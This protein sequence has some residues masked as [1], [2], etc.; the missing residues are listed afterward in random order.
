LCF[1]FSVV[2]LGFGSLQLPA[3][4]GF[5][6]LSPASATSRLTELSLSNLAYPFLP[7]AYLFLIAMGVLVFIMKIGPTVKLPK[8]LILKRPIDYAKRLR[9]QVDCIKE[10]E[11]E[12]LS[13]HFPL[14]LAL[15][16]SFV[17]SILVVVITIL[18]WIN[19]TNRLVV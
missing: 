18:P 9:S 13:A 12:P 16:I 6:V 15:L 11:F 2:E 5:K 17:V 1:D 10:K 4:F 3:T 14:S 19:P 8:R 7:Y